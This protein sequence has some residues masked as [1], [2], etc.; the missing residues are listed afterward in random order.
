MKELNNIQSA[1]FLIGG[2]MMVIGAGCF[3][4][5]WHQNV[6]CFIYLIGA[7]LFACMQLLQTY[8][9]S[10]FVIKRLKRIMSL[11]D[12]LF[13]ISGLLMV[14]NVYHVLMP[15]FHSYT[16]YINTLFNKWVLL[17]IVAAVLEIYTMHRISAELK[18]E[19]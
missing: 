4:F 12:V 2:L 16:T 11:A 13:V 6:A 19:N 18:K 15:M 9:G 8:E 7:C 5:I 14:D 10:N 1:M 17:L 3:A